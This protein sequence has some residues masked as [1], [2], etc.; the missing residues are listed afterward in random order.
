MFNRG[1][2]FGRVAFD[3]EFSVFVFGIATLHGVAGGVAAGNI[4]ATGTAKMDGVA[5][6]AAKTV[7]EIRFAAKMDG[8]AGMGAAFIRERLHSAIM[9]GIAGMRVEGSRFHIDRITYT[10]QFRP[11]DV[12]VINSKRLK[13]TKNGE[14][15]LHE[16]TG[17]FF[18]LN[19]GENKLTYTDNQGGRNI[20][21]RITYQDK[22][23]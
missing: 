4:T 20:L 10:G 19:L 13:I 21:T 22:F 17:D 7:R 1:A 12:I 9:H 23:V 5:G 3:R 6:M 2:A 8:V 11:G 15:I 18:D 16:M 14:N